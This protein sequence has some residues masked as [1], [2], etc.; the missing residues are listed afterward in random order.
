MGTIIALTDGTSVNIRTPDC[1]FAVNFTPGPRVG[2][3]WE[4]WI[5]DK[6][7]GKTI[8]LCQNSDGFANNDFRTC[9]D[10]DGNVHWPTGG[11]R[12]DR[13][14]FISDSCTE[15]KRRNG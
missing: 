14:A 11:T 5:G 2:S 8:G 9:P 10:K 13:L 6:Y 15:G 1:P 4:I 3:S 12:S 7:K